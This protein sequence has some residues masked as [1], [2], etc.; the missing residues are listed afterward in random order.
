MN[1]P[2]AAMADEANTNRKKEHS[3]LVPYQGKKG[4]YVIKS[5]KKRMKCL[6]PTEIVTK[7]TY[8]G[9]KLMFFVHNH[10]IIYQGRCPEIGCDDHYLGQT[11]RRIPERVLD[12]AERDQNSY[13]FK[14]SVESGHTV[15]EGQKSNIR[16]RKIAEAL[17]TKGTLIQI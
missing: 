2:T 6:L 8:V 1:L 14:H 17:L 7:I 5:M 10:D 3:L 13:L 16:K 4:E 15:Q 12:H 11:G 9:N